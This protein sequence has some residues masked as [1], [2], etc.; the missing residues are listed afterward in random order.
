[1]FLA[2][3]SIKRPVFMSMVLIAIVL[4]GVIAFQKIGIDLYPRV[5]FPVVTVLSTLPGSDPETIETAVTEP[6]EDALSSIS[7]IKH[8]RSISAEGISQVIIE[9]ELEKDV[10]V[11]YQEVQAKIGAIRNI[12]PKDLEGQ[13]IEK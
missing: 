11:A 13:Q 4:F 9:F 7:S 12:L 5:D 3:L 1:M 6:I 10:D 8:L 2:D